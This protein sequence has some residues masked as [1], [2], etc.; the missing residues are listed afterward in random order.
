MEQKREVLAQ[1]RSQ[2]EWLDY[3][4]GLDA[5]LNTMEEMAAEVG[6]MSGRF[7]LAEGWHRH[8][9][10]GFSAEEMD[11]LGDALGDKALVDENYERRLEMPE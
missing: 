10:L 1:H 11:P 9:H 7:K 8:N 2:K 4:Q 6:R 3:S 5:Y